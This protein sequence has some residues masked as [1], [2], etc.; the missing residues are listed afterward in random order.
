[1]VTTFI[2]DFCLSD[3]TNP[4][5]RSPAKGVKRKR[6]PADVG[7]GPGRKLTKFNDASRSA[8]KARLDPEYKSL[9]EKAHRGSAPFSVLLGNIGSRYYHNSPIFPNL[10]KLFK[11]IA[12]G[13][14][15]MDNKI[16]SIDKSR[17]IGRNLS[18][19]E[20]DSLRSDLLPSVVLTS[21][22]KLQAHKI[23]D[24]LICF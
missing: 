9:T 18:Q 16:F 13:E 7:Q 1:M 2:D 17:H 21:R 10:D 15:P 19:R 11:A 5:N 14:N 23:G 22:S 6:D 12:N 8:K 24:L 4:L 20:Y 3:I